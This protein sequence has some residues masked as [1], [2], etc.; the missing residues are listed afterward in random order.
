MDKTIVKIPVF[1]ETRFRLPNQHERQVGLWVDRIGSAHYAQRPSPALRILGQYAVVAVESGEGVFITQTRETHAVKSGDAFLLVPE[2]PTSYGPSRTWFSRWIVWNGPL[3][4]Q[5]VEVAGS[6]P[7][8]P[9]F[10]Q[11]ADVVRHAFFTLIKLM[12]IEDRAAALER[13]AVIL[14]M[15]AGLLRAR[16]SETF[17]GNTK[18]D[19]E[20]VVQHIR[21]HLNSRLTLAELAA[22]GHLSVPHFRRMFR[23]HIGRSPVEFILSERVSRAK[24]LLIRGVSIKQTAEEA[25]FADQF[26]FMRVFKK[27]TGQT[28]G[29]F[30]GAAH[31]RKNRPKDIWL[32]IIKK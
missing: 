9:V 31:Y 26:Y 23:R 16:R 5:Q 2:E 10:H 18:P 13:Q 6:T 25:G 1:R 7:S 32:K 4:R 12:D 27:V 8:N 29:Q 24:D 17:P 11:A 15:L 21:R 30:V 3:A 22:L 28:A 14:N 19:W 20:A